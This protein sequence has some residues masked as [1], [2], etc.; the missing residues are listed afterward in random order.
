VADS[1]R[2]ARRMPRTAASDTVPAAPD[3]MPGVREAERRGP[4]PGA[5]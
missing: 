1:L 4:R 5:R 3:T 2:T